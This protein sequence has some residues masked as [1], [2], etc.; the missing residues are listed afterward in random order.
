M[1]EKK[2][3]L[4]AKIKK[5]NY[6]KKIK[7]YINIRRTFIILLFFISF[8]CLFLAIIFINKLKIQ[9]NKDTGK[10]RKYK[11]DD[12]TL[13]T[14]YYEMVSKHSKRDY[15]RWMNLTLQVNRSMIIFSSKDFIN[16]IKKIRPAYLH[17]KTVFIVLEIEDF[18][19]YK[20][21]LNEFNK[22][23]N[24]DPEKFRHSV[25]LYL[26][27]AEKCYFV[28]KAIKRNYFN[29]TC[30]YWID[31]GYFREKNEIGKFIHNWPSSKKCYEDKRVVF[32]QVRKIPEEERNLYLNFDIEAHKKFQL[33]INVAGGMFGG[34]YPNVL[35]FINLY[36]QT[37]RVFASKNIFIGKDQNI[38]SYIA[39]A[40]PELVKLIYS[41]K[42]YF[43]FKIYLS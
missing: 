37:I 6:I 11:Q 21:Y 38:F 17:N 35:K 18:Y 39:F 28:K 42:Q 36:Y 27:W 32:V 22:T 30:F 12:L 9:I 41:Y 29:S 34:Y 19:S 1:N 31:V 13:V 23:H 43:Y 10:E 14:A 25:K 20:N 40:H 4:N 3:Y 26:V 2:P 24:I 33:K 16:K 5:E 15:L 8:L 7:D